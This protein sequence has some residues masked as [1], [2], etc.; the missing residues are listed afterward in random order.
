MTN[1]TETA[2]QRKDREVAFLV[3]LLRTMV[4]AC[5]DR[6]ELVEI[7]Q[8][9]GH[10]QMTCEV[11]VDDTDAGMAIGKGG[12]TANAM[13]KVLHTACKKTEVKLNFEIIS[14]KDKKQKEV[15]DAHG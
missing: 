2:Q 11:F 12:G 7:H 10:H 4:L 14:L 1:H 3:G 5:V 13:R 8:Q 6:P 15:R 9:V